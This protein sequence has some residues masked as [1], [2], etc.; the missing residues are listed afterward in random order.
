MDGCSIFQKGNIWN[1][2]ESSTV[3][4]ECQLTVPVGSRAGRVGP[5]K[6]IPRSCVEMVK[7]CRVRLDRFDDVPEP[8][9]LVVGKWLGGARE[10]LFN[11]WSERRQVD[12][13]WGIP[14]A[15]PPGV[16]GVGNDEERLN[17]LDE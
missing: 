10:I 11:R 14:H 13:E 5:S 8:G 3:E 12:A 9:H 16:R 17:R 2:Q 6:A 1:F 4:R 7:R 15:E